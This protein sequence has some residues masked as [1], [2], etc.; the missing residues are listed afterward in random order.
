M[1][2]A[3]PKQQPPSIPRSSKKKKKGPPPVGKTSSKSKGG[4]PKKTSSKSK[5]KDNP[6]D[7]F[8]RSVGILKA[9]SAADQLVRGG[10]A[11]QQPEALRLYTEGLALLEEAVATGS[12]NEKTRDALNKK[13]NG[14]R[15]RIKSLTA[16][17]AGDAAASPKVAFKSPPATPQPQPSPEP[18]PSPA[19]PPE[20]AVTAEM[21]REA[22][23]WVGKRAQARRA[24]PV[25]S[26]Q[27]MEGK[28]TTACEKGA[29]YRVVEAA[30]HA[31]TLRLRLEEPA[32]WV[33]AITKSGNKMFQVVSDEEEEE[34]EEEEQE[35]EKEEK[36]EKETV[37]KRDRPICLGGKKQ[38]AELLKASFPICPPKPGVQ[39]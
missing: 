14:V 35:E 39:I 31:G 25:H 19:P 10:D 37:K 6:N 24:A 8:K 15:K 5:K 4:S 34:E 7:P 9:A 28:R 1:A 21:Q 32:G 33:A 17:G 16:M 27:E 11:S 38:V 29:V 2:D 18:A 23:S 26:T 30:H 20:P 36:K 13:A 22:E 3:T 12:Y